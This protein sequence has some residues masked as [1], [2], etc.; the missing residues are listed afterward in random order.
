[1]PYSASAAQPIIFKAHQLTP[2]KNLKIL[3]QDHPKV[4]EHALTILINMTGDRQVL[5]T[6]VTDDKFLD[7]VFAKIVVS[8]APPSSSMICVW[9]GG[10]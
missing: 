8:P 3:I 6:V 2:I 10:R 4:A 5:E 7:T 9:E 1:M